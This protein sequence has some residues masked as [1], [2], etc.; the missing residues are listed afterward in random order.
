MYNIKKNFII[1]F[2]NAP[3]AWHLEKN[4]QITV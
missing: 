4:I 2:G 3:A 1:V